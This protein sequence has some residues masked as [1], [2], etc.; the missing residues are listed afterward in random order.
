LGG[1]LGINKTIKKIQ[2]QFKW[3]GMNT[4]IKTYIKNCTLCQK[5]KKNKNINNKKIQQPMAAITSISSKSFEK[6]FLDI[7]GPLTTTLSGNT[8]ILTM[9]NDLTKYSLGVP[10]PDHQANTMAEAFVVHFVCI[11]GI[12]ETILTDQGTEFLSKIFS[13]VCKLLKIN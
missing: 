7:V 2:K 9:Q 13:E 1:H 6:I 10:L 12:P 3:R 11:H 8:Y 5:N 4:D